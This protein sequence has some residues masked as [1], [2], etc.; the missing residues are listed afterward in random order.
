MYA[1]RG[2]GWGGGV[3]RGALLK[4]Y[5]LYTCDILLFMRGDKWIERYIIYKFVSVFLS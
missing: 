1:F 2:G 5:S 4:E 3:V